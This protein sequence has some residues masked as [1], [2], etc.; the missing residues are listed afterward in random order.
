MSTH[1]LF[2]I[3]VDAHL[4]KAASHTFG[5]H[6][7]YPVEL[8]RAALRRG[9]FRVEVQISRDRIRVWDNGSGLDAAGMETLTR[10][11]DPAQ[12]AAVK[13]N[14]VENLQT[15]EGMGLLALFAS[16]PEEIILENAAIPGKKRFRF[17]KNRFQAD[18]SC[19]S[20]PG[21]FGTC[22]SLMG[23][24][25]DYGR[26]KQLLE[27]FCRSVPRDLRLNNHPLGRQ[28]LLVNQ[29]AVMKLPSSSHA[30]GGSVGI[31]QA[32]TICHIRLLDQWIP[33]H[34][35]TLPVQKGFIF[36]AAVETVNELTVDLIAHLCD[37]ARQLYT[38]LSRRFD[39]TPPG[40]RE[41]I[42]ELLFNHCRL[43]GDD[44]LMRHFSPFNIY[45]SQRALNLNQV[46][47]KAGEGYLYA[48]PRK[49]DRLRYN[50]G[51][52]TVLSL[53][54]EQADLLINHL[55]IPVTFL[56]PVSRRPN[57]L[58]SY[59]HALKKG[60]KRLVLRLLPTPNNILP[61]AKLDK[62]ELAFLVALLRHFHDF[63]VF[64]VASRGPFPS[65]LERIK[66]REENKYNRQRLFIRRDHPL[67]KKAVA[68]VRKD[69]R[70]IE[71]FVPL[72][73]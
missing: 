50:T 69:P 59:A 23:S 42:E 63:R 60:F 48:V 43:T 70:N 72:L 57:P 71:I 18:S 4:K 55:N 2:S 12:P 31:P 26:E 36:D 73:V 67:V 68:A 32:G 35:F 34:H 40:Y 8:V 24:R 66:P 58:P 1:N 33:W 17:H 15:R 25:R 37:Y 11:M 44:S 30:A 6:A 5:S 16:N 54:R 64:M 45:G 20:L 7:H 19:P 22:V 62:D 51:G 9:A 65:V 41:R 56:N 10:L 49:K 53:P 52:K 29:M 47:Q 27:A 28:P 46:R 13:E 14:A 3:D 39:S 61:S 21:T 38:W